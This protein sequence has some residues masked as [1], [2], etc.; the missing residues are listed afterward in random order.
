MKMTTPE[1]RAAAATGT[2]LA[3]EGLPTTIED[4]GAPSAG[5]DTPLTPPVTH[6][7]PPTQA[8]P[9]AVPPPAGDAP[10][11]Q[12]PLTPTAPPIT[13]RGPLASRKVYPNPGGYSIDFTNPRYTP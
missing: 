7:A 11:P 12:T 9:A 1:T 2:G 3:G 4:Q 8:P 13:E 6:A 5:G 10:A